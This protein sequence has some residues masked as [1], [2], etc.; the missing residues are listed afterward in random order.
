MSEQVKENPQASN[1]RL[2]RL[3]KAAITHGNA[4][5]VLLLNAM[6]RDGQTDDVVEIFRLGLTSED[7]KLRES[8][9]TCYVAIGGEAKIK[10]ED[11]IMNLET[12]T[13]EVEKLKRSIQRMRDFVASQGSS[14]A[15]DAVM[16][17]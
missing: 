7:Q 1:D 11:M 10:I 15:V 4:N 17:Q 6:V 3:Y 14:K 2:V 12:S 13:A 16:N 8:L 9:E 5:P